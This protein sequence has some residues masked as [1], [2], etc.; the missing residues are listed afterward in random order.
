MTFF[1]SMHALRQAIAVSHWLEPGW[2][3]IFPISALETR[4]KW[5]REVN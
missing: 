4:E 3:W 2:G 1:G 5:Q